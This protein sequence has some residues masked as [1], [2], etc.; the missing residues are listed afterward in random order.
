MCAKHTLSHIRATALALSQLMSDLAGTIAKAQ[1]KNEIE[2]MQNTLPN[3]I[4]GNEAKSQMPTTME[5]IV[6]EEIE[7]K[8]AD[9]KATDQK[10]ITVKVEVPY[11]CVCSDVT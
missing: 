3:Y 4:T 10:M 1:D 11:W 7:V 2:K 9:W 5:D 6:Y 8:A